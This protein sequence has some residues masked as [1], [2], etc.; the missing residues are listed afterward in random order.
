MSTVPPPAPTGPAP[1]T[2]GAH[3]W[4]VSGRTG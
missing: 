3:V 2:T 1:A 4:P